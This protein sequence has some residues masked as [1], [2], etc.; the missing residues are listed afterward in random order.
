MTE[1]FSWPILAGPKHMT[2]TSDRAARAGER[3]YRDGGLQTPVRKGTGS[4]L[5]RENRA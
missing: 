1:V 2:T 4:T 3:R 5:D